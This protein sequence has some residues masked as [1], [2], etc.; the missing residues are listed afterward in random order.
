MP[1]EPQVVQAVLISAPFVP[2][3][4]AALAGTGKAEEEPKHGEFGNQARH[5]QGK[6]TH[7]CFGIPQGPE[8]FSFCWK[9]QQE[10]VWRSSALGLS[11]CPPSSGL[12]AEEAAPMV[13]PK[14]PCE[15]PQGQRL[16]R[17]ND[18]EGLNKPQ[19]SPPETTKQG[20]C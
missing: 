5:K 15:V 7:V 12:A 13:C 14:D 17:A 20:K 6:K 16:S 2:A 11:P 9:W 3:I 4:G 1:A 10:V 8:G 19:N 18:T